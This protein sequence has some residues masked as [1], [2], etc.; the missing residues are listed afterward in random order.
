MGCQWLS[1]RHLHA[2]VTCLSVFWFL[3]FSSKPQKPFCFCLLISSISKYSFGFQF[4]G[5]YFP[6]SLYFTLF[7]INSIFCCDRFRFIIDLFF[8]FLLHS[9]YFDHS[10][11]FVYCRLFFAFSKINYV[12]C[13]FFQFVASFQS[14]IIWNLMQI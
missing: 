4:P 2:Y 8:F 6:L 10:F 1:D 3:C 13:N 9:Y 11:I 5:I 7:I 12:I 14:L